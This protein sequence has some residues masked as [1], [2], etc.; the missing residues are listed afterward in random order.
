MSAQSASQNK[1]A[2][3][4]GVRRSVHPD[5]RK[6]RVPFPSDR[7][8][9]T[10]IH[11]TDAAGALLLWPCKIMPNSSP[12]QNAKSPLL[13]ASPAMNPPKSPT[14]IPEDPVSVAHS[15][16]WSC[17]IN[18]SVA[19]RPLRRIWK[20]Q[21]P[22]GSCLIVAIT[23]TLSCTNPAHSGVETWRKGSYFRIQKSVHVDV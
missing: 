6:C 5:H 14:R 12:N 16:A 22:D 19:L 21:C 17:R 11:P 15:R 7:S 9:R 1:A 10:N 2:S 13:H 8:R 18:V 3:S 20:C 23:D 4:V